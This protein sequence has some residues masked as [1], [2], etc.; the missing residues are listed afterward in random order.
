MSFSTIIFFQPKTD[1]QRVIY[2]EGKRRVG[3]EPEPAFMKD[4]QEGFKKWGKR[5][6]TRSQLQVSMV[7]TLYF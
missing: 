3:N 6:I 4:K 5:F 1:G 2:P 7:F